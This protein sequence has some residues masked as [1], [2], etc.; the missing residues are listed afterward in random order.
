MSGMDRLTDEQW[1]V[2]YL[3]DDAEACSA[4]NGSQ[5]QTT[6]DARRMEVLVKRLIRERDEAHRRASQA[7]PAPQKP[8]AWAETDHKGKVIGVSLNQY[9]WHPTPLYAA[10]APSDGLREEAS[11]VL[12]GLGPVHGKLMYE[13]Y[14]GSANA[15]MNAADWIRAALITTP[16]PSDALREAVDAAWNDAIEAVRPVAIT[17][18]ASGC[19]AHE[20]DDAIRA[21]RRAAPAEGEA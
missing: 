2:K 19:D 14:E 4:V 5:D 1:A 13:G 18:F 9:P 15:V 20:L 7:A 6:K 16:A 17:C 8:V 12:A 10:P 21:L 3:E 11:A